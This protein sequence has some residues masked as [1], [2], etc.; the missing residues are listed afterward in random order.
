MSTDPTQGTEPT[1]DPSPT[2]GDWRTNVRN[3]RKGTSAVLAATLLVVGGG[4]WYVSRGSEQPTTVDSGQGAAA[5]TVQL[6]GDQSGPAPKVGDPAPGFTVTTMDGRKVSLASLK[7]HPVWITFGATW[8]TACRAE[9]PDIQQEWNAKK[10]GGLEL[11]A[12]FI[13]EDAAT[14]R[15]YSNRLGLK[16]PMV[17]DPDTTLGSRYRS[18]G[19]PSHFFID[20]EGILRETHVGA[21]TPQMMTDD[22]AKIGA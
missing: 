19:I 4:A 10:G 2:S 6:A 13:S 11:L 22:L 5:A 21:L 1:T 16:F 3:S 20:K 9:A 12:V 7:G 15:G 18:I 14:V 8:C 17:S